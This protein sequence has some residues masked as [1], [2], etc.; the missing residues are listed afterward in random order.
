QNM[1]F[2]GSIGEAVQNA[3]LLKLPLWFKDGLTSYMSESWSTEDDNLLRSGILSGK[4]KK[5]NKLTGADAR[6]AGH[7][8]WHYI[9]LKYGE[10]SIPNLLYLTRINRSMESG[11]SF[12]FGKS[13]KDFLKEFYDYYSDQFNE[14]EK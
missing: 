7:A 1:M 13:V 9:A 6:F 8:V 5:M 11:F 2:G 14:D 10:A 4:Y 3:V 12:V